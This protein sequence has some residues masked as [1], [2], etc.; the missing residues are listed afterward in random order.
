[1]DLKSKFKLIKIFAHTGPKESLDFYNLGMS[2]IFSS[3]T[4]SLNVMVFILRAIL[5][6][7]LHSNVMVNFAVNKEFSRHGTCFETIYLQRNTHK[8]V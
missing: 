7:F 2:C 6:H 1:M 5:C 8:T 3:F 4:N